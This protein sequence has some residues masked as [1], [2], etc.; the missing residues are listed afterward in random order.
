MTRKDLAEKIANKTGV[1]QADVD[2]I[3][4]QFMEGVKES[5]ENEENVYLRG[6][7]TFSL[8][9]RAEKK[10]QNISKGETII[11]PAHKVPHF[12]P[13]KEFKDTFK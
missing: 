10:A 9:D 8:K 1:A 4:C 6:F 3:I 12:K 11:I 5:L 2:N 7:G 13:C